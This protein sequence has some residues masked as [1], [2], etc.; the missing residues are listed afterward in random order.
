M[1]SLMSCQISDALG[2]AERGAHLKGLAVR[3]APYPLELV[4]GEEVVADFYGGETQHGRELRL[5][6]G[7][8]LARCASWQV[9]RSPGAAS[10]RPS[11]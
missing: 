2:D 10:S 1:L 4:G 11:R 7:G 5:H 9:A 6:S 8:R 3:V